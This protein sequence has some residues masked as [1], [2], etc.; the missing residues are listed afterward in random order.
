[1]PTR[2][3]LGLF[4]YLVLL[5]DQWQISCKM[6]I[7]RRLEKFVFGAVTRYVLGVFS[8]LVGPETTPPGAL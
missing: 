8:Y 3:T 5:A 1:M 4:S 6:L 2:R 7:V